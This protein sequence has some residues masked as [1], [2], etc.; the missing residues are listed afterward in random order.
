MKH[1]L[2]FAMA[3]HRV[4]SFLVKLLQ[5]S[6]QALDR[7]ITH[8]VATTTNHVFPKAAFLALVGLGASSKRSLLRIWG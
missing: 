5:R 3:W 2:S 8:R 1:I 7:S 6:I 4:R